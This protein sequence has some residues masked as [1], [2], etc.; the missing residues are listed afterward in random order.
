MIELTQ[1]QRHAIAGAESPVVLDPE[2]KESYVLVRKEVFDRI[3][4]LLYDDSDWTS[5]E[6]LRLLAES[7][8]RAG[9]D[10]PEMDVYDNLDINAWATSMDQLCSESGAEDEATMSRAIEEHRRQ[11]KEQVRRDMGL[12]A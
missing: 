6:Q 11:A 12:P 1:E 10:A 5:D 8:K 3:K 2:T 7:G 9:W 4:A